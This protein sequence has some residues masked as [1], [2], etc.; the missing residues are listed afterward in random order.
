MLL[1]KH[2]WF[3]KISKKCGQLKYISNF[4]TIWFLFYFSA[5]TDRRSGSKITVPK[6]I[7]VRFWC[8]HSN[9]DTSL[10]TFWCFVN[11]E[12]DLK[13]LLCPVSSI[14][15][16]LLLTAKN[17]HHTLT[18]RYDDFSQVENGLELICKKP[19]E[20]SEYDKSWWNCINQGIYFTHLNMV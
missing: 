8:L 20:Q 1:R 5:T 18:C 6:N 3:V 11:P 2:I 7:V 14:V 9:W 4:S 13:L 15:Y 12:V 17:I 19:K 10:G 16:H